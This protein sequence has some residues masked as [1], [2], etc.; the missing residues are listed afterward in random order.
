IR[1][2]RDKVIEITVDLARHVD[3]FRGADPFVQVSV[4]YREA[5]AAA[6]STRIPEAGTL[7]LLGLGLG[8]L[9]IAGRRR[10]A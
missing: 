2:L 4:S 3:A 9:A 1:V 10:A 5:A 6:S 7:A 8:A